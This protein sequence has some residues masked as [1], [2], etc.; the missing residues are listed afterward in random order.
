MDNQKLTD[1]LKQ[2]EATSLELEKQARDIDASIAR[3]HT[4]RAQVVANDNAV[5][6]ARMVIEELLKE[7][8]EAPV[9]DVVPLPAETN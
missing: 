7:A 3:L 5:R 9:A 6:G 1:K 2:L 8:D 4:E